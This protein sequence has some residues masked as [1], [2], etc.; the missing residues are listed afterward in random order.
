MMAMA[1]GLEKV[2][3]ENMKALATESLDC[4]EL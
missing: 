1:I 4:Y 3:R 2:L